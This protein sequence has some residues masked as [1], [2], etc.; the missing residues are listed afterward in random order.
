MTAEIVV[1]PSGTR[2]PVRLNDADVTAAI[3]GFL[4]TRAETRRQWEQ[5]LADSI[6]ATSADDLWAAEDSWVSPMAGR[7]LPAVEMD[8]AG[9]DWSRGGAA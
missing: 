5:A 2:Q 6:P 4:R 8:W 9:L 3:E 1:W 7:R